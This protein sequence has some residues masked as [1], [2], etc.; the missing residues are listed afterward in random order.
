MRK[1]ES[2]QK[3]L[4]SPKNLEVSQKNYPINGQAKT[5]TIY[6]TWT[7]QFDIKTKDSRE[8]ESN[9]KPRP[10]QNMKNYFGILFWLVVGTTLSCNKS[11]DPT[12]GIDGLVS[13][14]KVTNEGPGLNCVTGGTKID[15]GID[16]NK[17]I[18][19][20]TDEIQS[21]AYICNGNNGLYSLIN[22]TD[23]PAG[24]NCISGGY[25][26]DTGLDLNEDG[27]LSVN[28]IT[29]TVFRCTESVSKYE[30]GMT[31]GGGII[32]YLDGSKNH[33]LISATS[34]QVLLEWSPTSIITNATGIAVGTGQSNTAA[35]IAILG[36]SNYA[37]ILCDQLVLN[38]YSDW[39]LPS[40]DELSYLYDQKMIVGGF[41]DGY[42]WSSTETASNTAWGQL[43]SNG[44]QNESIAKSNQLSIRA[45]RAF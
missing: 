4:E 3:K 2:K 1:Q 26:I 12:P 6:L 29:T 33:G 13:L 22:V 17:N 31:Y 5:N 41:G 37:A 32:F 18:I 11:N 38:G 39:F 34:D 23:E 7:N 8:I 14:I 24:V 45:I 42:Y 27:L 21:S 28:E 10:Y 35:I 15:T 25:R 43:F 30:I 40:K 36:N 9:V 20:D 44:I 16:K 19:L